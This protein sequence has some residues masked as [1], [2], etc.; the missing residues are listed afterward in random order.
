MHF[1]VVVVGLFTAGQLV[2]LVKLIKCSCHAIPIARSCSAAY[3]WQ[4]GAVKAS[5]SLVPACDYR[6]PPRLGYQAYSNQEHDP[7][8]HA[9]QD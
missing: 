9:H 6:Q 5:W 7:G 8:Q 2:L 4:C 1:S 3:Q